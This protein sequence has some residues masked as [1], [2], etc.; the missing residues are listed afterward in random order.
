MGDIQSYQ[1]ERQVPKDVRPG[2]LYV[3]KQHNTV[4]IPYNN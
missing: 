2:L 1:N 4:L 3:D